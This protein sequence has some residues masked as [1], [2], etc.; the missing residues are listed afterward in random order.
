[1]TT[2]GESV[3]EEGSNGY[4]SEKEIR[5]YEPFEV[6]L[7]KALEAARIPDMTAAE[8]IVCR[9]V[10]LC[11]V[12]EVPRHYEEVEYRLVNRQGDISSYVDASK[13]LWRA[14]EHG[15]VEYKIALWGNQN[16][17]HKPVVDVVLNPQIHGILHDA[18]RL[19][20]DR[21]AARQW[22]QQGGGR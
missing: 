22:R 8:M 18:E 11:E 15:F 20:L 9:E 1:M 13:A 3:K 12:N 21:E 17:G 5:E 10:Y 19:A 14:K 2:E 4:R 7:L 6:V 16:Y